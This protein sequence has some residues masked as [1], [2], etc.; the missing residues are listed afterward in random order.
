[1]TDFRI[2]VDYFSW[3]EKRI[4]GGDYI[5]GEELSEA[6]R[7]KDGLPFPKPFVD[8]LCR[9]L[10]GELRRRRGRPKAGQS[11]RQHFGET[12]RYLEHIAERM[13]SGDISGSE[14]ADVLQREGSGA[15]PDV[16]LDYLC[17][18]VTGNIKKPRG[19]PPLPRIGKRQF[20]M[21]IT[22]FYSRYTQKLIKRKVREGRAAGWT[23]MT[24]SPSELAARIVAKNFYYGEESWRSVQNIA[25]KYR[26]SWSFFGKDR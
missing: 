2:S 12:R 13:E 21:V 9:F 22:G 23:H 18:F 3:L 5:T 10:T 16:L 25:S 26:R 6:L 19:R 15:I 24:Y 7:R 17:R 8:A 1:M 11:R 20:D 4:S 14:L